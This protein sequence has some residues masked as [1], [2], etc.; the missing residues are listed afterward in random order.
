MADWI[1]GAATG[2]LGSFVAW[3][4]A[5]RIAAARAEGKQEAEDAGNEV[6]R[7]VQAKQVTD[8]LQDLREDWKTGMQEIR[9]MSDKHTQLQASQNVVNAITQKTLE[10]M[11]A[12]I[13][14]HA[15]QLADQGST[16]RLLVDKVMT[17]PVKVTQ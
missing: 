11:T 5:W 10:S 13:E 8:A 1:P 14:A 7:E 3:I 15:T 16:I 12:K 6:L 17:H 9:E 2:L 4:A